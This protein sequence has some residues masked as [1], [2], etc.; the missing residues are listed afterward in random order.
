LEEDYPPAAFAT[1]M[2]LLSSHDVNRAVRVLDH[3]GIDFAA[4]EPINGFADGRAAAGAGGGAAIHAARRADDLLR[5]RSGAGR[6]WQRRPARRSRTTASPIPGLTPRVRRRCRRG[7]SRTR[8]CWPTTRRLGQLRQQHSFL[9]TGAWDTL[10]LDDAGL[11]VFGRKD[12][13]GA[14]IVAVNRSDQEQT[15]SFDASGYLPWGAELSD[16]FGEAALTVGDAGNVS[17]T[18][19]ALGYQL[20]VTD[21]GIDFTTP[22]TPEIIAVEESNGSITLTLQ[23]DDTAAQYAVLRSLVDGGF[24]EVAIL[25]GTD[26]TFTS[27]MRG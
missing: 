5:R 26:E 13:S 21:E 20:W 27:P 6:L 4:Q 3:D 17:F 22:M 16:P 18:A 25:P 9:R 14:A 15:V 7:A 19:P 12:A 2:N 24:E 8:R 10:L 23:G 1:A 11:I